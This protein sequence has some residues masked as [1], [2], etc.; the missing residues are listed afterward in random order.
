[1]ARHRQV[2]VQLLSIVLAC[3]RANTPPEVQRANRLSTNVSSAFFFFFDTATLE[4]VHT[5]ALT[6]DA[7]CGSEAAVDLNMEGQRGTRTARGHVTRDVTRCYVRGSRD[8]KQ[9]LGDG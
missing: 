3:H 5:N 9:T 7:G 2:A 6:R 1:M 8:S 4:R